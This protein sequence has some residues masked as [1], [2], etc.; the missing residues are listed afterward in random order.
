MKKT[1][2]KKLIECKWNKEDKSI[3]YLLGEKKKGKNLKDY[4]RQPNH[5]KLT[6]ITQMEEDTMQHLGRQWKASYDH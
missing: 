2:N 5:H 3:H 1:W 6:R 4:Q